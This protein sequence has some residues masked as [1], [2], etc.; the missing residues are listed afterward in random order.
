MSHAVGFSYSH[1]DDTV[2]RGGLGLFGGGG[3]NV[4]LSNSYGNDEQRKVFT[5]CFGGCFDGRNIPQEILDS[6]AA[7]G[8]GGLPVNGDTNA[9]SPD[10]D[11]PSVWKL[12]LG[13]DRRQNLG[14]LGESW[15]LS[16]ELILTEVN[17]AAKYREL[18]FT[19]N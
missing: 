14:V 15:L 4:W 3:P 5:G 9:I 19:T 12:N 1:D 18:K 7:G 17:D 8:F 10:F 11:I 16:S 13:I 2:I 6:L